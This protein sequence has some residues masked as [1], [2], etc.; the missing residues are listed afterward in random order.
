MILTNYKLKMKKIE[1]YEIPDDFRIVVRTIYETD[2]MQ[3]SVVN[4]YDASPSKAFLVREGFVG[5]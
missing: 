2:G 4:V 5:C 3:G 1:Q